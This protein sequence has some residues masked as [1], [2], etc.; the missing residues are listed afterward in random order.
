MGE[1]MSQDIINNILESIGYRIDKENKVRC[2][3]DYSGGAKDNCCRDANL[4]IAQGFQDINPILFILIG[5]ILGNVLS[6]ALPFNVAASIANLLNFVGQIIE[7]YSSQQV[8]F[9]SGPGRY[10]NPEYRNVTNSFCKNESNMISGDTISDML[11]T[12]VIL[13]KRIELLEKKLESD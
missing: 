7:T 1:K 11:K 5:E 6:G 9:Q 8:Y 13:N 10:Y 2:T 4:D 12:I 3:I